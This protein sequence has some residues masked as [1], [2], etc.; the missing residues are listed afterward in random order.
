M[1]WNIRGKHT[2][3]PLCTEESDEWT[4]HHGDGEDDE[5]LKHCSDT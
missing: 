3:K 5:L 1:Q 2:E 4:K